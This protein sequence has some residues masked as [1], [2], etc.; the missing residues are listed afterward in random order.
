MPKLTKKVDRGSRDWAQLQCSRKR[1]D[2]QLRQEP[3]CAMCLARG[4]IV[5]ATVADH[6][7]PHRGDWNEFRTGK[8]QSLCADCHRR[9]TQAERGYRPRPRVGLDGLHIAEPNLLPAPDWRGDDE[10]LEEDDLD[11]NEIGPFR[12]RD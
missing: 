9:K 8:L 3:L 12:T 11:G 10:D 6:I 7:R 4:L 5:P 1:R 2:F